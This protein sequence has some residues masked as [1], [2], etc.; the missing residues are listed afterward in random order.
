MT[1]AFDVDAF[2][3]LVEERGSSTAVASLTSFASMLTVVSRGL[4]R[5]GLCTIRR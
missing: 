2:K 5:G 1:A 3:I 4:V